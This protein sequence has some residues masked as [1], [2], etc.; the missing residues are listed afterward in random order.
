[1]YER[2]LDV[3]A[4]SLFHDGEW[5]LID[6]ASSGDNSFSELI[7]YRWRIDQR[8]ALVVANLG[9]GTASGHVPVVADLPAGAA[10]DSTDMLSGATY[11][12]TRRSLDVRGLFVRLDPG[13]A[14]IFII[15]RGDRA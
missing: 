10:F 11:R 12:W 9:A 8:L 2:L 3:T 6:V 5:K 4:D 13:G 7:A 15:G 1:M 14:H